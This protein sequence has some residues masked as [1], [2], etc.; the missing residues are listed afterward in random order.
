MKKSDYRNME[1][2]SPAKFLRHAVAVRYSVGFNRYV[3]IMKFLYATYLES[4]QYIITYLYS[5]RT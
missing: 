3:S 1:Q 2:T 5:L 4:E